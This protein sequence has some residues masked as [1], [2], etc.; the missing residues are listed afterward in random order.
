MNYA[1]LPGGKKVVYE[2]CGTPWS[3]VNGAEVADEAMARDRY[4]AVVA[5]AETDKETLG[6]MVLQSR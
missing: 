2:C 1:S 3:I 4:L 6:L 5:L